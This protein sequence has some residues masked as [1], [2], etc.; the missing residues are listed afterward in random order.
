MAEDQPGPPGTSNHD[1]R[2]GSDPP[3]PWAA[4][5]SHPR[6]CRAAPPH[7]PS[8]RRSG[9]HPRPW[10]A[11]GGTSAGQSI[12]NKILGVRVLDADTGRSLPYARAFVR[13]LMSNL[14]ALPCF[15]GFFWMLWDPRKRTWHDIVANS[16]VVRTTF[17]PPGEFGRLAR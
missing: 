14:S 9:H 16:L 15:L 10:P 5:P 11:S 12:G 4:P 1:D 17:Y 6:R 8:S 7:R 3:N 13:A 2:P